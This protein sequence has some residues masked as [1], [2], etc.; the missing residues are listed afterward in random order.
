MSV[1]RLSRLSVRPLRAFSTSKPWASLSA[2]A[3][4]KAEQISAEWKGTSATGGTTKN[5]IGGEFIES[6]SSQ[7]IDIL[8]PVSSQIYAYFLP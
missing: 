7:W 1:A 6:K 5:F 2:A 4:P 8:D 3:L